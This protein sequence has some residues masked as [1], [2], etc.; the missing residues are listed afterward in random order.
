[1]E[2][3]SYTIAQMTEHKQK[4]AEEIAVNVLRKVFTPGQIKKLMSPNDVRIRWSSEDITSAIALR[5]LSAK[6]YRYLRDVK[7]IPLPCVATL[8]NWCIAFN[9][10]P[11]IL[12]DVL[13]IMKEKDLT[14]TEK[15]TV[16]TF[17]EIY[18]SNKLD[19][20]RK[21]QKIYGPH[22][23]CQFIMAR[24]LFKKWKQPIYYNFD[25]PMTQNIMFNVIQD[26]YKIG[27]IVIAITCDMGLI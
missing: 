11:G 15:L 12:K 26:L 10:P 24:G 23:T 1:M 20:E 6:T 5:S 13:K 16:L 17:D 7:K 18:I 2:Q 9:V 14:I 3:K 27:Y 4:E 21:E 22:K 19:L 8:Q 25:Q